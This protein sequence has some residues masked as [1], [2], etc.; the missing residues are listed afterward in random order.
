MSFLDSVLNK[1]SVAASTSADSNPSTAPASATVPGSAENNAIQVIGGQ[2][3]D[4]AFVD[5]LYAGGKLTA[6][7]RESILTGSDPSLC[8]LNQYDLYYVTVG[9]LGSRLT[10]A[11][12]GL[13]AAWS[14]TTAYTAGQ[15]VLYTETGNTQGSLFQA[16]SAVPAG[17][18]PTNTSYWSRLVG[19]GVGMSIVQ[20]DPAVS[21]ATGQFVTYTP[22]GGTPTI[23]KATAQTQAGAL[24]SAGGA[25]G[26]VTNPGAVVLFESEA[27]TNPALAAVSAVSAVVGIQTTPGSGLATFTV[28][29]GRRYRLTVSTPRPVTAGQSTPSDSTVVVTASVSE[30]AGQDLSG[31]TIYQVTVTP[32]WLQVAGAANQAIGAVAAGTLA[33]RVRVELL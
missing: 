16:Q 29:S 18:A 28:P 27:V 9:R 12:L 2:K 4:V 1:S 22:S 21:Y 25:W 23:Y 8:G 7:Q 24:P 20:Y 15:I 14:L 10:A 33:V 17:T 6:L 19:P 32:R 31:N 26:P 11:A 13:I 3:V 5:A 30:Q